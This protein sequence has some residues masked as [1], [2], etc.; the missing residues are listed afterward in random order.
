MALEA[1]LR[2]NS[3]PSILAAWLFHHLHPDLEPAGQQRL[4]DEL[5]RCFIW[6]ASSPENRVKFGLWLAGGPEAEP[7]EAEPE[8]EPEHPLFPTKRHPEIVTDRPAPII[9]GPSG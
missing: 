4:C 5:T 6:A 8:E 1:G 7:D 3:P 2:L 9:F